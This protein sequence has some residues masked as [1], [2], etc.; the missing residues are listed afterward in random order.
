MD[1]MAL[2]LFDT[3]EKLRASRIVC[4]ISFE[5]AESAKFLI[6]CGNYTSAVAL[7]RLQFE[8]L[9]RSM[10]ILYAASDDAISKLMAELNSDPAAKANSLPMLSEMLTKME[11]KAPGEAMAMLNEFKEYS[12]KALSSFVHGGIHAITRHGKGYP[13]QL[14]V[15]LLKISNGVSA[16]AGMMLVILSGDTRQLGKIPAIQANFAD[17]LPQ[18]K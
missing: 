16:M 12:W 4:S 17:C 8:A 7:V 18:P 11:G 6:A 5:H 1:F 9:V 10:W 2:P 15:Q 14:L 13:Q 3:S